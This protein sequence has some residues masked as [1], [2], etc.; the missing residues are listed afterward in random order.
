MKDFFKSFFVTLLAL[1][2]VGG[3]AL[4]GFFGLVAVLGSTSKPTVPGKA[5]LVFNLGTNLTDGE[6]DP[7]PGELL[8]E[9]LDGGAKDKELADETACRRNP[10]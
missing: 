3:L 1:M 9:A 5:V 2:V 8:S 10:G 7:E 4:F 6:R